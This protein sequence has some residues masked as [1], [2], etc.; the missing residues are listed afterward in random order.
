MW[1][2]LDAGRRGA[3]ATR[4]ARH[5]RHRPRRGDPAGRVR[6]PRPHR[7]PDG[8]ADHRSASAGPA[9]LYLEPESERTWRPPR[10]RSP[11]DDLPHVVI[12][13]GSNVLVSDRGFQ[14][15]VLRLGRGYR[16]AARDGDRLTA[17]GSMPLPA[18]AGVALRH[19]LDGL[20]FGVAIPAS[21]GGAVKMNAGSPR[22]RRS[23]T[24]S[25][26]S[27]S[28][29][30]TAGRDRA[31]DRPTR[32]GSLSAVGA[33]RRCGRDG[34]D[35]SC[36]GPAM[37]GRRSGRRWTRRAR[38]GGGRSLWPSPTAAACSRTRPAGTPLV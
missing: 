22:A 1:R 6:R 4:G 5:E 3:R 24:C 36:S 35:R 11:K 17:G 18:L 2:R 28:S 8:A 15:L 12:G 25:P 38:G 7:V 9:A 20:A 21:L 26:T 30:S 13:K 32:R 27:T 29:D 34:R 37:P 10:R 31:R 33:A 14:G 16:W 19:A 23:P